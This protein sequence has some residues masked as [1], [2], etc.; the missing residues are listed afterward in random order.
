MISV[1]V[2]DDSVVVRR[3]IV[4]A[5]T[6]D[7]GIQVVGTASNG[8]LALAKID[9]LKPDV[10]TLDIEM[11]VLDGLGTLR[12]LRPK[13]KR[14]PV[15]MFSTLTASGASATLEALAAG[16]SDYVTKPANVGSVR[17]SIK[18]VRE[19][20]IPRIYA[21]APRQRP[22]AVPPR[23]GALPGRPGAP[24]TAPGG[25]PA[26]AGAPLGRPQAPPPAGARPP[27][28][29]APKTPGTRIDVIAVGCSTG[30]PDALAKVVQGFPK[31]LPVPVVVVQHMPPIFT[32]MF[33]DRLDRASAVKVVEATADTPLTAGT[34]YIAPG[35]KHLE[36]IRR[37][38]SVV[39][40]LH[41]GPP[42]NSCRPAVDPLFRSVATVY[43]A[44]ALT[45][46]L[47][48]MGQDGKKGCEV[49]ARVGS[50]IVVQDEETSV[51]WGM[52]GAVAAAG[53]ADAIVPL[54]SIS[55]TLLARVG[56][57]RAN[58]LAVVR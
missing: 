32:K 2:V 10:V 9:E 8:R 15:I 19:Q 53:L 12:E 51:V 30:G 25:P 36:V 47:T 26:R 46:V 4:D 56:H 14:L 13:H 6:D 44:H 33:A 31:D 7:P 35:D 50:E 29:A 49:L 37:G 5:L 27:G 58:R 38:T 22:S 45:V 43:G 41:E 11:P 52:P 20:L 3:L 48:G 39:T 18:S 34:V 40:K 16:A 23:P 24:A 17:E 28:K 57:G 1:L 54:G 42:E 21:L 55:D